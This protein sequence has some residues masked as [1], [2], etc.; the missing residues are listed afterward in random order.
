[1]AAGSRRIWLVVALAAAGGVLALGAAGFVVLNLLREELPQVGDC[2]NDAAS[3]DDMHVVACDSAE[4]A[5]AV[6][7]EDGVWTR[8]DFDA[9]GPGEVCQAY[10]TTEQAM[11]VTSARSMGAATEG[12]VVCLEP[13]NPAPTPS[14]T[15]S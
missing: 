9:A 5:W 10:P 1:V 13:L 11:W 14:P 4:A 7:G 8:G 6:V 15:G 2:L 12:K 3:V